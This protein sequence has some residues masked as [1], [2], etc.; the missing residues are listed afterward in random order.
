MRILLIPAEHLELGLQS[1]CSMNAKDL[2]ERV[3][4]LS[5]VRLFVTPWTGACQAPPSMGFSMQ[6]YCSGLPFPSPGDLPNP[7]IQPGSLV[8]RAD[9]LLSEPSGK[10]R[11]TNDNP[12]CLRE[13]FGG[14]SGWVGRAW[15]LLPQS[16]QIWIYI[17]VSFFFN[18]VKCTSLHIADG[19]KNWYYFFGKETGNTF[20]EPKTLFIF[21]DLIIATAGILPRKGE[22]RQVHKFTK[23]SSKEEKN[24]NQSNV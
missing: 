15:R 4:P 17:F 24:W 7:Q 6:E 20:Q 23:I 11:R 18:M 16:C 12:A 19:C 9:S 10:C 22:G 5:P 2:Q 13:S 3:G 21:C 8:L 1:K 14:C